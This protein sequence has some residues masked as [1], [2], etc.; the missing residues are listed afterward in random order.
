MKLLPR[1]NVPALVVDTVGGRRF[2]L[3][4]RRPRAFTLVVFYR[5]HH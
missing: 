3:A 2:D 5:G 1:T 4:N